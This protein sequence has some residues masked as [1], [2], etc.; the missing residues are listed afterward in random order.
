MNIIATF[1]ELKREL[2]LS[3]MQLASLRQPKE[4]DVNAIEKYEKYF[5]NVSNLSQFNENFD[6]S[7]CI[8]KIKDYQNHLL[9][10]E[11]IK[12][13][14]FDKKEHFQNLSQ[15][16]F[17]FETVIEELTS[18]QLEK[19][20]C[21]T[22]EYGHTFAESRAVISH[23]KSLIKDIYKYYPVFIPIDEIKRQAINE[24]SDFFAKKHNKSVNKIELFEHLNL[25]NDYLD[26][27]IETYKRQME[28]GDTI[29]L[30]AELK[31]IQSEFDIARQ[32]IRLGQ[33]ATEPT[34][35]I[36]DYCRY[37][38]Y[39]LFKSSVIKKITTI[40]PRQNINDSEQ[41]DNTN[42]FVTKPVFNPEIIDTLFN[43]IKCFFSE[44]DQI[45]LKKILKSGDNTKRKL[46]FKDNGNRLTDTFKKL[47]EINCI[48]S[49]EKT[50]LIQWI[51]DNF[52]Y[53][54][55]NKVKD[56]IFDTVEKT[57]SRNGYFC[58]SPII[59]IE[60]GTIHKNIEPRQKKNNKH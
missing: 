13:A 6:V 50:I 25:E 53:V 15:L 39:I 32:K 27:I 29:E 7:N 12:N 51:I 60:N 20:N 3:I 16:L 30:I 49:C 5:C 38:F 55:R 14:N 26:S 41:T 42:I 35:L 11:N 45:E 44:N 47:Y 43:H 10:Y 1:K 54:Y 37:T 21:I 17:E 23:L 34:K 58:K 31:R 24:T 57:I 9:E 28:Q 36:N 48:T 56:Y 33:L 18:T 59:K 52:Q 22:R 4:N 19:Y 40:E 8:E 2:S 46:I